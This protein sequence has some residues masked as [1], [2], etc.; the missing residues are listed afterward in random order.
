LAEGKERSCQ[1]LLPNWFALG[2]LCFLLRSA[3]VNETLGVFDEA[4]AAV[5]RRTS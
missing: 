5:K 1:A 3:D 2:P 4:L